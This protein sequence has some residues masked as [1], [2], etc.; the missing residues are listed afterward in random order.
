MMKKPNFLFVQADQLA[1]RALPP[2]RLLFCLQ[3]HDQVGNRP[4]GER[5]GHLIDLE[6]AKERGELQF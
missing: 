3:N 4:R 1:A 5:L 6:P 2:S